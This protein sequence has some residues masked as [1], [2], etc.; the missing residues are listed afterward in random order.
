L[1][2]GEAGQCIPAIDLEPGGEIGD[3]QAQH[4]ARIEPAESGK[5]ASAQRPSDRLTTGNVPRAE[6]EVT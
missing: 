5:Q 6:D 2:E 3:R 4:Q 1:V